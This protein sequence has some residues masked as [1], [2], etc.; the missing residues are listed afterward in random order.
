[1]GFKNDHKMLWLIFPYFSLL[2]TASRS[3]AVR[4]PRFEY[5]ILKPVIDFWIL[6]ASSFKPLDAVFGIYFE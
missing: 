3:W 4:H 2:L 1:M 5:G 6:K